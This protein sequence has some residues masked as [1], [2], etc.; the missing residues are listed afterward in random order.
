MLKNFKLITL[1]AL[2]VSVAAFAGGRRGGRMMPGDNCQ[3]PKRCIECTDGIVRVTRSMPTEVT[4]GQDFNVCLTAM[5]R[6]QCTDV[7]IKEKIPNGLQYVSSEPAA[8]VSEN[9]LVWDLGDLKCGECTQLSVTYTANA[10]GCYTSCYTV[11]AHPCCCQSVYVG[12][13]ELEIC[14][15]GTQC[16]RLGC[17]VR[18]HIVVR[19]CGSAVA[20]QVC[21]TDYVPPEL[22]HKS[23]CRELTW[24]LGTLCPGECK[25]IDVDF[26]TIKCGKSV[27]RATVVSCNCPPVTATATTMIQDCCIKLTKT[28]PAGPITVGQEADY[29]IIAKNEGNI[30]LTNVKIT[31]IVPSGARITE[32]P[33]AEVRGNRA[34]WNIDSFGANETKTFELTMVS[35]MHGCLTN[36]ATV[37]CCE[38]VGDRACAS[39][40]W[41]GL[42]GLWACMKAS[43]NPVCV[44]MT[45]D[46]CI[47]VQNQGFADDTNV[48]LVVELPDELEFVCGSGSEAY[49]VDGNTIEFDAIPVL[50]AGRTDSFCIRAKGVDTGDARVKIRVSSDM[51]K[52][53]VVNEESIQ[54][55]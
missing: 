47:N 22:Q 46:F 35:C 23:C 53:A 54:V 48:R 42:A 19:N 21:L 29:K 17:P 25:S 8:K 55:Y 27:N 24:S 5:A 3:G 39:T 4:L 6:S 1:L 49:T 20:R 51:L 36:Q 28:G 38:E 34:V 10:E 52:D 31:D 12:C 30:A 2:S 18:Y 33:G 50:H 40:R 9:E 43:S 44:G 13:P 32:A 26:C 37:T 7:V 14:K 11:E 15:T 45:T 41:V 16:V